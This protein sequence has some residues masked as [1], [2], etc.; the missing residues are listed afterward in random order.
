MTSSRV[1][2]SSLLSSTPCVVVTDPTFKVVSV[3]N[4][5]FSRDLKYIIIQSFSLEVFFQR[6]VSKQ[7]SLKRITAGDV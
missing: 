2:K 5:N 1:S 4:T 3:D 6:G 7:A